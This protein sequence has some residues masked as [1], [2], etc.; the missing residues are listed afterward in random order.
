MIGHNLAADI[1]ETLEGAVGRICVQV[2]DSILVNAILCHLGPE[3]CI[4]LHVLES[5]APAN[6]LGL[7]STSE[8]DS[9]VP[10]LVIFL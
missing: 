6:P 5:A 9:K 8:K 2:H 7:R 1:D 3:V 4:V 10:M